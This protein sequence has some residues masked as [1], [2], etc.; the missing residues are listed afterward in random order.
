MAKLSNILLKLFIIGASLLAAT[1][2]FKEP[3]YSNIPEIKFNRIE[4][5]TGEYQFLDSN[6]TGLV[7]VDFMDG[8]GD[9]GVVYVDTL[10]VTDNNDTITTFAYSAKVYYIIPKYDSAKN[11]VVNTLSFPEI[12][13]TNAE[14]KTGYFQL[15]FSSIF[16][17]TFLSPASMQGLTR[18][19]INLRIW[20]LDRAGNKSNVIETPDFIINY[21]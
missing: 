7:Y 9:L 8:D 20:M 5:N 19:T 11:F 4:I 18:D 1:A 13:T 6:S 21:K 2:C 16:G 14:W 3:Q 10:I 17:E 15:N 12:R